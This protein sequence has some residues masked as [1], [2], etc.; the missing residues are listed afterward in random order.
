MAILIRPRQRVVT[1]LFP[2]NA[3]ARYIIP[4][5]GRGGG[6]GGG[7]LHGWNFRNTRGYVADP[8]NHIGVIASDTY[9]TEGLGTTFGWDLLADTGADRN[10]GGDPRLAGSVNLSEEFNRTR[11]FSIDGPV[12]TYDIRIAL[13]DF[14]V[15]SHNGTVAE[16]LDGPGVAHTILNGGQGFQS[17]NNYRDAMGQSRAGQGGW[18]DENVAAKIN[19]ESGQMRVR[20]T[21]PGTGPGSHRGPLAH[22]SAQ[23]VATV[24]RFSKLAIDA[25]NWGGLPADR[26]LVSLVDPVPLEALLAD[27]W[28][29]SPDVTTFGVPVQTGVR[30]LELP[31]GVVPPG[32]HLLTFHGPS[33][34]TTQHQM[35]TLP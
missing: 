26:V 5:R 32:D 30:T 1:A 4:K 17:G 16:L 11:D 31:F 25:A 15:S 27:N 6:L 21:T 22:V 35:N 8:E 10:A 19:V 14:G 23:R 2:H 33:Y 18:A 7:T 29:L 20:I 13:G 34:L 28:T 12:G 24:G 3:N 9:P